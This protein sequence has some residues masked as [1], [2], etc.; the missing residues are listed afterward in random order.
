MRQYRARRSLRNVLKLARINPTFTG[1]STRSASTTAAAEAGIP[2]KLI[3]DATD[4]SSAGIFRAHYL[5]PTSFGKETFAN[6][7]ISG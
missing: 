4:W 6:S 1:H 7:V 2:L 3:L 5:R